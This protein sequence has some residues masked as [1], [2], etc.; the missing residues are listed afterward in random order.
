MGSRAPPPAGLVDARTG[1][2]ADLAVRRPP[3][4]M[5]GDL[6]RTPA[7]GAASGGSRQPK[8]E[9][10]SCSGRGIGMGRCGRGAST[11]MRAPGAGR[12]PR[13]GCRREAVCPPHR[14][15]GGGAR[16]AWTVVGVAAA[17]PVGGRGPLRTLMQQRAGPQISWRWLAAWVPSSR[18]MS[19]PGK[20]HGDRPRWAAAIV[21]GGD[22]GTGARP[23][24][25]IAP[26]HAWH[27]PS[28]INGVPA[29]DDVRRWSCRRSQMARGTG[30]ARLM[31]EVGAAGGSGCARERGEVPGPQPVRR[32]AAPRRRLLVPVCETARR[33]GCGIAQ[34]TRWAGEE[35]AVWAPGDWWRR[36]AVEARGGLREQG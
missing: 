14:R 10:A 31:P 26:R 2:C 33:G 22:D 5:G 32:Q 20:R 19:P 1:C 4:E 6:S 15:F 13:A 16:L 7:V 9:M 18:V 11:W 17:A 27:T 29:G 30:C 12:M 8:T 24:S 3:K 23:H 21:C 28:W 36:G 34:S 35:L 25:T